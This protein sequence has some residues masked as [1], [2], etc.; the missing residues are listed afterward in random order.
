MLDKNIVF[1]EGLIGDDYRYG[2]TQDGKEY[3]TFS[4]C[5]NSFMR[6]MA[7]STERTHSQTYVRI[8][9]YDKKQVGYLKKV[10]AHRGMRVSIFGRLS[11]FKNDY[12][13]ISFM[14][15]SVI[16]RDIGIIKTKK[17]NGE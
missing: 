9:I 14:T 12:K 15:N 17:E 10:D 1:L 7:D 3:A 4:L 2:K 6:D 13:G 11:S 8:F 16:C 5:C